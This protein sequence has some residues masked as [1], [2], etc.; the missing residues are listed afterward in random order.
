MPFMGKLKQATAYTINVDNATNG[1]AETSVTI[2]KINRR[3]NIAAAETETV[4]AGARVSF[5]GMAGA[6]I[7]RLIVEVHPPPNG[8]VIVDV[9]Q[10]ATTYSDTF[11]GDRDFVFNL[12]S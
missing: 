5:T 8:T 2:V 4:A 11:V 9:R 6:R 7:D 1:Q 12:V 10:A 3:D